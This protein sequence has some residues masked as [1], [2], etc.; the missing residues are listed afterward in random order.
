MGAAVGAGLWHSDPPATHAPATW[1]QDLT[2]N[3]VIAGRA[4]SSDVDY[5]SG[6]HSWS[7]HTFVADFPLTVD[8]KPVRLG[9]ASRYLP[10][11]GAVDVDVSRTKRLVDSFITLTTRG[12]YWS[13][14][15]HH[16][17][18]TVGPDG[19]SG[20]I[21]AYLTSVDSTPLTVTGSWTCRT[22]AI[23]GSPRVSE[24]LDL[25]GAL[26][27]HADE[28]AADPL[29]VRQANCSAG[30]DSIYIQVSMVAQGMRVLALSLWTLPGR[31]AY[32]GAGRYIS[33]LGAGETVSLILGNSNPDLR[34]WGTVTGEPVT[35][36]IGPGQLS[37]SVDANLRSED[38]LTRVHV[39]GTFTCSTDVAVP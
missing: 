37:G 9:V 3:G 7:A 13:A 39:S 15:G 35:V 12:H 30:K 26:T 10:D 27:T 38:G 21:D 24:N 34:N 17:K 31:P 14:K 19:Q 25:S 23:P 16:G 28:D 33:S 4:R 11:G 2:L 36:M 22:T 8:G 18:F 6:A 32:H 5:C 1:S 20:T 29:G